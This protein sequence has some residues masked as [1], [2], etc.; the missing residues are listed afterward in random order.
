MDLAIRTTGSISGGLKLQSMSHNEIAGWT[1]NAGVA[2]DGVD[3]KREWT[4]QEWTMTEQ[5]AGWTLQ[6]WTMTE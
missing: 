6:E 5:S 3:K 4:L 2:I 1:E